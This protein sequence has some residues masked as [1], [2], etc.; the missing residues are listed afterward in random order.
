MYIYEKYISNFY[1]KSTISTS[2]VYMLMDNSIVIV[3]TCLADYHYYFHE[4]IST[5]FHRFSAAAAAGFWHNPQWIFQKHLKCHN[6]EPPK[7]YNQIFPKI[8]SIHGCFDNKCSFQNWFWNLSSTSGLSQ[9]WKIRNAWKLPSACLKDN[10]DPKLLKALTKFISINLLVK[11]LNT[12]KNG[13]E[14]LFACKDFLQISLT[15]GFV[16]IPGILGILFKFQE[17]LMYKF[18]FIHNFKLIEQ[19]YF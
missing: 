4:L 6:W 13:N 3:V 18:F 11:F 14:N 17:T 12:F 10:S 2:L 19:F 8:Q 16:Q 1:P 9:I 5:F 7:R 15:C